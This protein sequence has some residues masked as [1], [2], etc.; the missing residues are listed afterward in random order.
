MLVVCRA[1]DMVARA[2]ADADQLR[3]E[4]ERMKGSLTREQA[5]RAEAERQVSAP[6][7]ASATSWKHVLGLVRRT[8]CYLSPAVWWPAHVANTLAGSVSVCVH[9]EENLA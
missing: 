1:Q 7:D 4:L 9:W 8:C 2:S 3:A 6:C 5:M